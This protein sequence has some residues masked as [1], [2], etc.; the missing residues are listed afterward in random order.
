[1]PF[2]KPVTDD[3]YP[4]GTDNVTCNLSLF[5]GIT[6]EFV[7]ARVE[8]I[9]K[10]PL[11][12]L[13]PPDGTF[14]L[15]QVPSTDNWQLFDGTFLFE[16]AVRSDRTRFFIFAGGFNYFGAQIMTTCITQMSSGR[17]CGGVSQ[18]GAGGTVELFWGP[19]IEP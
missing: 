1:M 2:V 13:D 18:A 9:A 12:P 11:A 6:P 19:T 3:S 5:G 17:I 8:G 15:T 14:L 7:E 10:C 16:W 4:A